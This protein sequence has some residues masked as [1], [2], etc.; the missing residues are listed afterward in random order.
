MIKKALIAAGVFT[1]SAMAAATMTFAQSV[2]P[3]TA[4]TT[5]TPTTAVSAPTAAPATGH[6]TH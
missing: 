2:T 4:P 5:V 3:T 1:V 6:A